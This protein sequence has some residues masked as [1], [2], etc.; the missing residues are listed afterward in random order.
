MMEAHVDFGFWRF[1]RSLRILDD[2]SQLILLKINK[3]MSVIFKNQ[4]LNSE[5]LLN[6]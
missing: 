1:L 6:F 2:H 5:K 4:R 3:I